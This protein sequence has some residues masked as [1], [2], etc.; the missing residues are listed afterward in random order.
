MV[1]PPSKPKVDHPQN[2]GIAI[3]RQVV[4]H[5]SLTTILEKTPYLKGKGSP[6]GLSRTVRLLVGLTLLAG[7]LGTSY[8]VC[9][10]ADALNNPPPAPRRLPLD[11]ELVQRRFGQA[12][13]MASREEVEELLGP[14]SPQKDY[15]PDFWKVDALVEAHPDRY[16]PT[17][18]GPSGP[19]R[20]MT[21]SG[22]PFSLG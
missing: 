14:P 13:L 1:L 21:V 18:S 10:A 5:Q 12:L 17:R 19:T 9:G 20:R 16:P 11:F 6:T 4:S 8:F 3:S 2:G 15:E 22:S 7:L